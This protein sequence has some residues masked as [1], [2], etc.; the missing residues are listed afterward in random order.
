MAPVT[1]TRPAH[2]RRLLVYGGHGQ[3]GQEL[4]CFGTRSGLTIEAPARTDADITEPKD[5]RRTMADSTFDAVVNLAAYTNVDQAKAEPDKAFAINADGALTVAEACHDFA[6][7]LI[8]FSTDFV[9]DGCK[10]GDCSE[11][12]RPNPIS[13]YG[14]SKEAGE[15]AVRNALERHIILRTSWVFGRAGRNFVKSMLRLADEHTRLIVVVDQKTCPTAAA[16][17][18]ETIVTPI[19]LLDRRSWGTYHLAGAGA[20]TRYRFAEEIFKERERL[21]GQAAPILNPVQTAASPASAAWPA[22]SALDCM[23]L[24]RTFGIAPRDRRQDLSTVVRELLQP[25]HER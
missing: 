22:N 12:D 20:T 18:A 6:I 13:T 10:T 19:G 16:F 11:I 2:A 25:G 3:I 8:H 9:F 23:R 4:G 17:I 21:T 7:P 15:R 5:V 1:E 14:A 24:T